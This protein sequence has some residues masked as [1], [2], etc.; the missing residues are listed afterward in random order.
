MY[1]RIVYKKH[2]VFASKSVY[3]LETL[4]QTGPVFCLKRL[5][6]W[7][8]VV[9]RV[10]SQDWL[11]LSNSSSVSTLYSP[12]QPFLF[13]SFLLVATIKPCGSQQVYSLLFTIDLPW[14][15][16]S[17]RHKCYPTRN[18]ATIR[19]FRRRLSS[20]WIRSYTIR[21]RNRYVKWK[22]SIVGTCVEQ[23]RAWIL[24]MC[25]WQ[26]GCYVEWVDQVTGYDLT[27]WWW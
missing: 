4:Y 24:W 12:L 9:H 27:Q 21:Y 6:E 5:S 1:Q 8:D 10:T 22:R 14:L 11:F 25:P 26:G 19:W 15:T 16:L 13:Y 18:K 20:K 17:C 3:G 7:E 2:G 23:W